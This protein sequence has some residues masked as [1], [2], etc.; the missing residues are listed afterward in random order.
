M[1]T[2]LN[3]SYNV[4]DANVSLTII[5]GDGQFGSSAVLLDSEK[6][7]N[8]HN[9]TNYP[10]GSGSSLDGKTLR[11]VTIVSDTNPSTTNMD[12]TYQFKGGV[13]DQNFSLSYA[14]ASQ[15]DALTFD[16]SFVFHK[17]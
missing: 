14:V 17:V 6:K 4:K 9:I 16:A 5:I 1:A 2:T 10:L 11:I 8:G 12:V 15:G 7:T 3:T 13:A